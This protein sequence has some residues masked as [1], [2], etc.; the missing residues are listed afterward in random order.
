MNTSTTLITKE[1]IIAETNLKQQAQRSEA[2]FG[3][4]G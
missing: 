2:Y 4:W 3:M 1:K